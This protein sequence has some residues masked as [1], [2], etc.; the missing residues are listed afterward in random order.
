MDK[1]PSAVSCPVTLILQ[2]QHH[3]CSAEPRGTLQCQRDTA[4]PEGHCSPTATLPSHRDT[5][6]LEGHCYPRGTLLFHG[7]TSVPE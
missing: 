4:I 2:S 5:P 3:L 7:V 6:V 1:P